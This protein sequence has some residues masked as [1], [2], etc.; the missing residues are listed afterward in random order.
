[1]LPS[2]REDTIDLKFALHFR[3]GVKLTHT[4]VTKWKNLV[5]KA[6]VAHNDD[7]SSMEAARRIQRIWRGY[8]QRQFWETILDRFD[9]R[10]IEDKARRKD[11]KSLIKERRKKF[12]QAHSSA[13]LFVVMVDCPEFS[14]GVGK[15]TN[16]RIK[17]V[18][19]CT[20]AGYFAKFLLQIIQAVVQD[21][22]LLDQALAFEEAAPNDENPMGTLI[23]VVVPTEPPKACCDYV[24]VDD[25]HVLEVGL[26]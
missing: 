13:T 18:T 21:P 7:D 12:F 5:C 20:H 14:F 9:V 2:R 25:K 17:R 19:L 23:H 15:R 26:V 16:L 8:E 4:A 10:K 24:D 22:T 1:M 11:V 6:V 3:I